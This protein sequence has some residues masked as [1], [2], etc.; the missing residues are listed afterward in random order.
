MRAFLLHIRNMDERIPR[1][2]YE[3]G[4]RAE[5]EA[6]ETAAAERGGEVP[7]E[8]DQHLVFGDAADIM[9]VASEQD[10]EYL[11]AKGLKNVRMLS[12]NNLADVVAEIATEIEKSSELP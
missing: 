9:L 3:V 11:L 12:A 10:R 5:G 8:L 4:P 2:I 1:I 6:G 7:G